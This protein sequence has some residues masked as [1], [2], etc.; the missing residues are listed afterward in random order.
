M[1]INWSN[2][3][4]INQVRPAGHRRISVV[5]IDGSGASSHTVTGIPSD[6]A[7]VN[8][9]MINYS[10]DFNGSGIMRLRCGNGSM[11][12]GSNY[13]WGCFDGSGSQGAGATSYFRCIHSG[14][15][16]GSHVL[17]GNINLVR[18]THSEGSAYSGWIIKAFFGDVNNQMIFMSVGRWFTTGP[19]DR[20]VVYNAG[21]GGYDNNG[22][23]IT[24]V[25]TGSLYS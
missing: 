15:S 25:S 4:S 8:I 7:E 14:H 16:G 24:T 13:Q 20:F 23:M 9:H 17:T 22:R 11:D 6:A 1:A 18:A 10:Q 12:G 19:M 2:E 3:A 21:G 5:D